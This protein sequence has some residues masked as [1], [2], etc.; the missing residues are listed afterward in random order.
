LW[1]LGEF[2]Q[3]GSRRTKWGNKED[4]MELARSAKDIGIG[5]Y[6]DA[7]LNHKAGADRIE[8]CRVVEVDPND[9]T[10][11]I[12]QPHEIDGWLGFEF[13]GRGGKYS[14]MKWHWYHFTGTDWDDATRKKAIYRI[15]GDN[16]SWSKT[17]DNEQGNE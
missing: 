9:R 3:K 4:L 8:K 10:K 13:E 1:D 16:K 15:L 17:V 5:L 14:N 12:S 11:D 6:W 7:V 2:E